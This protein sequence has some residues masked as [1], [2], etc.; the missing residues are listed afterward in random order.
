MTLQAERVH[1]T[2]IRGEQPFDILRGRFVRQRFAPHLHDTFALGAFESG[3]ARITVGNQECVHSA[4]D[5]IV[6]E[7]HEVHTGEPATEEGWSYRMFYV[8]TA[9]MADGVDDAERQPRFSQSAYQDPAMAT[10]IIQTHRLLEGDEDQLSKDEALT[11]MLRALCERYEDR[12]ERAVVAVPKE[13][14]L[15]VRDYLH[16]HYADAICLADLSRIAGCSPYHL[17]RQFSRA[18]GLPPYAYLELVRVNRAKEMLQQ[19]AR[20]SDVAFATRFS[21]QSHLTR[22]FKRVFGYPPG[23]YVRSYWSDIEGLPRMKRNF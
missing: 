5:V 15:R 19:G 16:E 3:G 22:R 6:I 23:R 4:G 17:I 20:I 18:F 13:S 12:G 1:V 21:D 8:P 10:T 14:L 11:E 2:H 7:P 9:L